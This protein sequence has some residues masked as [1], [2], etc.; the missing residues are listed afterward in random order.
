MR[1]GTCA[2]QWER[3]REERTGGE[4]GHLG[5]RADGSKPPTAAGDDGEGKMVGQ[6]DLELEELGGERL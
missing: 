4:N 6:A 2:G 3:G 5:G 1:D